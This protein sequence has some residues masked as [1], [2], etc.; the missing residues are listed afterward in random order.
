[1]KQA[2]L[3]SLR[4]QTQPCSTTWSKILGYFGRH[5]HNLGNLTRSRLC[6]QLWGSDREAMIM[7]VDVGQMVDEPSPPPTLDAFHRQHHAQCGRD[8]YGDYRCGLPSPALWQRVATRA[9]PDRQ[10]AGDVR[11]AA[12]RPRACATMPRPFANSKRQAEILT[13]SSS[14]RSRK[15]YPR[16]HTV[17]M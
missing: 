16:P 7:T 6:N 11:Q 4:R 1:M 14:V 15:K 2:P 12:V 10:L 5:D 17:S 9:F 13:S 8:L 3:S